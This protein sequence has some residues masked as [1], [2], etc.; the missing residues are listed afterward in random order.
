MEI[1]NIL[2]K[3]RANNKQTLSE[4]TENKIGN[5]NYSKIELEQRNLH[6]KDLSFIL[7][8]LSVTGEELV[9]YSKMNKEQDDYM[10][11]FY[12]CSNQLDNKSLKESMLIYY[13]S[14]KNSTPKNLR[15][16]ANLI[17]I[18]SFFAD[19]WVEINKINQSDVQISY[20]HLKNRTFFTQFDYSLLRNMCIYYSTEM[21]DSL[22]YKAFPIKENNI[23]NVN[24]KNYASNILL[25]IISLRIH[26]EDFK[27]AKDY[28][29][30][31]NYQSTSFDSNDYYFWI[32]IRYLEDLI[33]FIA[34]KDLDAAIRVNSY[35]ETIRNL[36]DTKHAD[37]MRKEVD[38]LKKD[39]LIDLLNDDFDLKGVK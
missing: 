15:L 6:I 26:A 16:Y 13:E 22:I 27:K 4:V 9:T 11:L 17:S 36:G 37:N 5:S 20:D 24:I 7:N 18:K 28:L 10:K 19:Y 34:N 35:I 30:V 32:N 8:N 12:E 25:N 1:G 38:A 3:F 14:I 39:Y 23:H 33:A 31:A 2:K 21:V 29:I